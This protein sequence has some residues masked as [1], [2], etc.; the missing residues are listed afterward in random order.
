MSAPAAASV[1]TAVPGAGPDTAAPAG[2]F[3]ASQFV[4]VVWSSPV[5]DALAAQRAEAKKEELIAVGIPA[6]VL[7]STAYP[8]LELFAGAGPLAQASFLVY[9]G[10]FDGRGPA[11]TYCASRPELSGYCLPARPSPR[12]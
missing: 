10:P 4:D 7:N 5:S 1:P 9:V 12:G 11:E 2:I 3:S 8:D 6:L